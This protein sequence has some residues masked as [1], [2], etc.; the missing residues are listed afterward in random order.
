MDSLLIDSAVVILQRV[1]F[2]SHIDSAEVDSS[3]MDDDGEESE[4]EINV[5]MRGPFV[6]HIRDTV[7]IDFASQT[8]P[9]G[10]YDGI[11]FKVHRLRRGEHHEDSD[12]HGGR[13]RVSVDSLPYG[14]SVMIWG[15]VKKNGAWSTFTF[16]FDGELEFKVKGNFTV[17]EATS[18]VNFALNFNMGVWF[19]TPTGVLL[20]PTDAS[21]RT[22]QL[23]RESIK[24]S[25]QQ[26]RGG[27]DRDDD[28]HPD[29]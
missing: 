18:M 21:S 20:D 27:R 29:D 6:V 10:T 22:R 23:I 16:A 26:C 8:L 4:E 25:F 12:E 13:R 28:G 9:A 15:W 7:S 11:K 5:T 3:D 19:T 17:S 24:R 14:S 1:K 2:E